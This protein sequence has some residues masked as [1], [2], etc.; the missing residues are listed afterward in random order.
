MRKKTAEI[1]LLELHYKD[2]LELNK[3]FILA[4]SRPRFQTPTM[5]PTEPRLPKKL[6]RK[7]LKA[8]ADG[9]KKL[10]SNRSKTTQI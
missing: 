1:K 8:L 5:A 9:R 2:M 4:I 10:A 6:S 7:Q 3:N